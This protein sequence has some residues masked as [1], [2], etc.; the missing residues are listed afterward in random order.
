MI[1]DIPTSK[2]R[3][4]AMGLVEVFGEVVGAGGKTYKGPFSGKD[5]VYCFW[6][7]E[8]HYRTRKNS[9]WYPV[10]GGHYLADHFFIKDDTGIVLVDPKGAAMS[11]SSFETETLSPEIIDFIER[12]GVSITHPD[13]KTKK[14]RVLESYIATSD[15]VYVMGTAGNNPFVKDGAALTNEAGIMIQKGKS[16]YCISNNTEKGVLKMFKWKIIIGLFG[17]SLLIITS[18]VILFSHI[19]M[20]P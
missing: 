16:F 9:D 15:K 1:E 18:L 20:T 7:I 12:Q 14:I 10:K 11:T 6:G 17:G 4:L 8:E 5:C 13:G 3:S 2:I 19:K